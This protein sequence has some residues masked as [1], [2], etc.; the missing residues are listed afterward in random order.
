MLNVE[1]DPDIQEFAE[2]NSNTKSFVPTTIDKM[3][4]GDFEVNSISS[5][6][7][8]MSSNDD[9][10]LRKFLE[11]CGFESG[12][13]LLREDWFACS[14][15]EE[16]LFSP[17]HIGF[18]QPSS[19]SCSPSSQHIRSTYDGSNYSPTPSTFASAVTQKLN[20]K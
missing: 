13:P 6:G 2:L 15:Q 18:S 5:E 4:F 17:F 8:S 16:K 12:L 1:I 19:P 3:K 14:K 20:S 11:S 7:N 9:T 10:E